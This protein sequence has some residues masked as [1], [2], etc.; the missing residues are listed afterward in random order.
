MLAKRGVADSAVDWFVALIITSIALVMLMVIVS[1]FTTRDINTQEMETDFFIAKIYYTL[2]VELSEE[3]FKDDL[4]SYE[5]PHIAANMTISDLEGNAKKTVYQ[6]EDAYTRILP[7][8]SNLVAGGG[9]YEN[10]TYPV[11]YENEN[12]HLRIEVVVE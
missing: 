4:F 5:E 10:F 9:Y 6:N 2:G 11:V 7:L 12:A 8:A 3:E 1:S